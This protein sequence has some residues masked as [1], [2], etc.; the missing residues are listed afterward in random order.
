MTILFFSPCVYIPP[1]SSYL[2]T[3][4]S[5]WAAEKKQVSDL[6]LLYRNH[7]ILYF[8]NQFFILALECSFFLNTWSLVLDMLVVELDKS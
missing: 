4:L 1:V 7:M 8:L 3:H 2:T 5:L 6:I